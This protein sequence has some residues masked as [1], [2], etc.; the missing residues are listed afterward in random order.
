M[1]TNIDQ[2][3]DLNLYSTNQSIN[4]NSILILLRPYPFISGCPSILSFISFQDQPPRR[5]MSTTNSI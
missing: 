1:F 3:S 2:S 4:R 5:R